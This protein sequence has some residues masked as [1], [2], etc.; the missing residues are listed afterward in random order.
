MASIYNPLGTI[1]SYHVLEKVIYRE[2]C[3]EKIPWDTKAPEYLKKIIVKWMRDTSSLNNELPRSVALNKESIT[4]VDLHVFGNA[5]IVASCAVVY[6]V[7][8]QSSV[9]NQGLVVSKSH[10][11]KK[12]LTIPRLELLSAHMASNLT[13]YVKA[14]LKRCNIRLVI[15]WIDST[16]VLHW[17]NR[18]GLYK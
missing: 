11:S 7:V 2:L 6:A 14:A 5:S 15:W 13:E 1:S 17:L 3:D 16:V 10:I 12:N 8:H 18:Q 4:A 9:R